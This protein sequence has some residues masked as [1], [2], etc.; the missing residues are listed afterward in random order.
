[1]FEIGEY[2][3][4]GAKGV[5][6]IRDIT[7]IDMSGAD[8]EKLY[9]VLAPVGDKNGTIYVPKLV[10]ANA[11]RKEKLELVQ[12]VENLK[13]QLEE[14]RTL[15]VEESDGD[16]VPAVKTYDVILRVKPEKVDQIHSQVID[17]RKCLVIPMDED[18]HAAVN[19]VNTTI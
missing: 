3:V 17:G 7:H 13:Q 1:M 12:Q 15:P 5:C 2:V 16:D 8:K 10:E 11:R 6:Q 18:E 19:G 4:C 14:T 9:Y